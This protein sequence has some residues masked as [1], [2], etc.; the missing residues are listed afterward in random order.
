MIRIPLIYLSKTY[1]YEYGYKYK[2]ECCHSSL[3]VL[4]HG[5]ENCGEDAM[6]ICW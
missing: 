5:K 4:I 1:D 2:Y 6:Y 3:L